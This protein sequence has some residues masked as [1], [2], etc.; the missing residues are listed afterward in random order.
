MDL[1]GCRV[2]L[3][4]IR[5]VELIDPRVLVNGLNDGIGRRRR[6]APLV[7]VQ[8]EAASARDQSNESGYAKHEVIVPGVSVS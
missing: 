6:E 7:V 1:T 5:I 2:H 3:C 4:R 8:G